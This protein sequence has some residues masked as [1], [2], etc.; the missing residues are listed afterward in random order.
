MNVEAGVSNA[1]LDSLTSR[2]PKLSGGG[3]QIRGPRAELRDA[4]SPTN[5]RVLLN[6][7]LRP[8]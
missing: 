2:P 5:R 6:A 7:V 8:G 4:F 3:R 1:I